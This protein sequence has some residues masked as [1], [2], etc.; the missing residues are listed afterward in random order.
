LGDALGNG[1]E[2]LSGRCEDLDLGAMEDLRD[3][4]THT[5]PEAKMLLNFAA[6]LFKVITPNGAERVVILAFSGQVR[7]V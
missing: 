4:E 5:L 7:S 2:R 3:T 1:D 6:V